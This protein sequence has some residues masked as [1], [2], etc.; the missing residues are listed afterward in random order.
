[1]A[2]VCLCVNC[3][4]HVHLYSPAIE[5]FCMVSFLCCLLHRRFVADCPRTS[6]VHMYVDLLYS[7]TG[8]SIEL[9]LQGV[10]CTQQE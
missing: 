7:P 2:V 6:Y 5:E 4:L 9:S 1:M 3:C 10:Y 8:R